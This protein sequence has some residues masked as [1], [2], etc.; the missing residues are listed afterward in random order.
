MI[1]IKLNLT[2]QQ[3]YQEA[4]IFAASELRPPNISDRKRRLERFKLLESIY[5][6]VPAGKVVVTYWVA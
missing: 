3:M 2:T 5:L 6:F 1:P 4:M